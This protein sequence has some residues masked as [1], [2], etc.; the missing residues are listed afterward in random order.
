MLRWSNHMPVTLNYQ[1]VTSVDICCHTMCLAHNITFRVTSI[2]WRWW[3]WCFP[4]P[5]TCSPLI[6]AIKI[7]KI[8]EQFSHH[9]DEANAC[10]TVSRAFFFLALS[11]TNNN[12]GPL[13]SS[14]FTLAALTF[15]GTYYF[16]IFIVNNV[17]IVSPLMMFTAITCKTAN[18]FGLRNG[19][20]LRRYHLFHKDRTRLM[21]TKYVFTF[22]LSFLYIAAI[23]LFWPL[24]WEKNASRRYWL[25]ESCTLSLIRK[26]WF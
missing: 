17:I 7:L 2:V 23:C 22:E 26:F 5:L 19:T 20:S 10:L 14:S 18:S 16:I 4:W 11:K 8:P 3:W 12:M 1:H 25:K 9:F 6:I 24:K 13:I 21:K 15:G